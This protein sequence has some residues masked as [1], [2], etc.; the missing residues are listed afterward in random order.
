[1]KDKKKPS[2]SAEKDLYGK[3]EKHL[4]ELPKKQL[5]MPKPK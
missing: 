3:H 1:M 2:K 4:H 5:K